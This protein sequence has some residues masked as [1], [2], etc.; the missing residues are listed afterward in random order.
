MKRKFTCATC[1]YTTCHSGHFRDHER[2][3]DG[4]KPYKCTHCNYQ[5]TVLS[6]LKRHT[7]AHSGDNPFKC[8][9]HGCSYETNDS[10]SLA[11]HK[12]IH[13]NL[14]PYGCDFP[15][16]QYK[17][18]NSGNL[19]THQKTHTAEGQTR[20]KRQERNLLKKLR[21]WGYIVD[22]EVT[23]R[24]KNGNCLDTNRYFSRLDFV[25]ISCTTHILIVECDEDQHCWYNVAC[26]FSRMADVHASLVLA[27]YTLPLHWIRYNPC[28]RYSIGDRTLRVDREDREKELHAYI[29][30]VCDGSVAP[31]SQNSVHYLYYDRVSAEGVPSVTL[32]K[33]FPVSMKPVVTYSMV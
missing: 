13:S 22:V 25:V 31:E 15:G 23:I 18:C 6:S 20:H 32:D 30:S 3:H 21:S 2:T 16:C 9:F 11:K 1:G 12:R 33:D 4:T 14:R 10:G 29:R 24:A 17:S 27:G 7:R 28:G 8:N 5:C 26:E 19:K